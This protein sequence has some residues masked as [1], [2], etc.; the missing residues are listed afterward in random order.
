MSRHIVDTSTKYTGTA[1]ETLSADREIEN[2]EV[3]V[4]APENPPKKRVPCEPYLP[5]E[6][7][8]EVVNLAIALGRPLLLQGDPGCGKTRLAY[9]VAYELGLPLEECYI[10][11]TSRAQDLLY[12]YDAVNRLYEAQLGSERSREISNYI[13]F[14]PLGRSIIR[15]EYG[16]RSVVLIDEIDKADIDFPN[17][18]LWELDRL[19]FRVSEAPHMHYAVG[20]HP[21]LRPIVF[22]THN[23]EKPLPDAFLRRCIFHHIDFPHERSHLE[24]ILSIHRGVNDQL[25]QKAI[26]VLLRLRQQVDLSKKPG[27][28][29][30]LDWVGYL[31]AVQTPVEELDTLP[32]IGALLKKQIDQQRAKEEFRGE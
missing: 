15:A 29:E 5:D 10:K 8:V 21:K 12:T 30:L 17:D 26:E 7:L 4:V 22:I 20:D 16:R 6:K 13:H 18:L 19:T 23:E 25:G 11:S 3:D 14:G 2:P 32:Y 28:S 24:Q 27:V 9:A 31:A 1:Y